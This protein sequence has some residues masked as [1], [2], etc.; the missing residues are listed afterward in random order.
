MKRMSK[1]W[2]LMGSAVLLLLVFAGITRTAM[3]AVAT[4]GSE[5]ALTN[6]DF[7]FVGPGSTFVHDGEMLEIKTEETQIQVTT[8]DGLS[9]DDE[10]VWYT[11][12]KNIVDIEKGSITTEG[13]T[14]VK[15][16]CK[17]K[18]NGPGY[19]TI[20]AQITSGNRYYSVHMLVKV[21]LKIKDKPENE[22]DTVYTKLQQILTTGEKAIV[23]QHI[24]DG[25]T[26]TVPEEEKSQTIILKY[27]TDNQI[28]N[29]SFVTW[30]SKDE[31]VA[32][33]D[34]NGKVTAVG[35]GT[36]TIH[37]ATNTTSA[38]EKSIE[39]DITVI[40]E[41][42]ANTNIAGSQGTDQWVHKGVINNAPSDFFLTTNAS[43]ATKLKWV[44]MDSSRNIIDD[45]SNLLSYYPSPNGSTLEITSA[46]AGTYYI[47][48]FADET[49]NIETNTKYLDL[50]VN[51]PLAIP[52]SDVVMNVGNTYDLLNNLNAP[53][54]SSFTK[55]EVTSGPNFVSV[56][57]STGVITAKAK[58]ISTVT[59]SYKE[60]D[61]VQGKFV[62]KSTAITVR[63]IDAIALNTSNATIFTGSKLLLEAV[64]TDTTKPITWE[65]S[66]PAVATVD[67]GLVTGVS[68]GEVVI[69]AKQV[70][71]GVT[72]YATCT[73]LVQQS[74][75][76]IVIDPSSYTLDIGAF[77]NLSAKIT[78]SNLGNIALTWISSDETVAKITESGKKFATV[79]GVSGG[80][81]VI[82]AINQQNVVVGFCK[83]T[84]NQ[85]VTGIVLNETNVVANLNEKEIQLRATVSPSNATNTS[86]TWSSTDTSVVRVDSTG[87]VT[88][89]SAGKASIIATSVDKPS[90]TAVC[91]IQ[92][93]TPVTGI[94]LDAKTKALIVGETAR[95]TYVV[96]PTSAHN[97]TV[98][99][100]SSDPAVATVDTAGKVTALGVG[101]TVI[102]VMTEDGSFSKT[103]TVTVSRFAN[104][105]KLD[106]TKLTLNVD[107]TYTFKVTL[108][109]ADSTETVTWETSNS[110]VATVNSSGKVTA[111]EEGTAIIIAKSSKGLTAYCNLTVRQQAT[112]LK[113]NYTKKT[114]TKGD[115]FKLKAV[116]TPVNASNQKVLFESSDTKVATITKE[117]V[118][119]GIKGGMVVIT[120][121]SVD[122]EYK[123]NCIVTVK[124]LVTSVSLKSSYK[125]G[126]GKTYTLVAKVKS[127]SA[128]TPKLKWTT[129]NSKIA[130]VD[131][132]GKIKGIRNGK[133]IITATATDGSKA[134]DECEVRVV[135]Q[136]TSLAL[137]KNVLT[138]VEGSK[139]KLTAYV[140]PK[141]ATYKT[142]TWSSSDKSIAIVNSKGYV[143]GI[144]EGT[145]TITASAKDS[146]KKKATC[147]V[148]VI[149][150][151]PATSITVA[152]QD[153]VMV[154]GEQKTVQTVMNPANT[155]DGY[156]W[157][158]DNNA[159]ATVSKSTGKIVAKSIGTAV[160]TVMTDSGK[161][162]RITVS[163]VGLSKSSLTLEQYSKHRLW[164]DGGAKNI[165]WD[166][167]NPTIA[168]VTNGVIT[169]SAVGRTRIIAIVNG[170]RLYCNLTVTRI[171]S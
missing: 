77:V 146:S 117:G 166:V 12:N 122:G 69:T 53:G 132:K 85:P 29:N 86:V 91:N 108:T 16:A 21:D 124:E 66:D 97:K 44:V 92:V 158:S 90:I 138:V 46:K 155:T 78:P 47:Q 169:T 40:V 151:V 135:T 96:I 7:Y 139:K 149:P 163:V 54:I 17:L 109:P 131:K 4:S 110:N 127:N 58:G 26:Q 50:T 125:L 150:Q 93:T 81:A 60:Y 5:K 112:G 143:S 140:R 103:C 68:V 3:A 34:R 159:V 148:K 24:P 84:V 120:A 136:V 18:R 133:V 130:T 72:K 23:L 126:K 32:K 118:V 76:S 98:K 43:K 42:Q 144:K 56:N 95:L 165:T 156:S 128:T 49:Y 99:W 114:V 55:I 111:K 35:A 31:T 129:S 61:P 13:G 106:K 167:E 160:I 87:K 89:V 100:T 14:V 134:K 107:A 104:S 94:E 22:S 116:V 145:V 11:S 59:L 119:K 168:T 37:I 62:E 1:K 101:T 57:P 141:N 71:N 170:R 8:K 153:L 67:N 113:L 121:T 152:D 38:E 45:S 161:K 41:P 25:Y 19:A 83:I 142:A 102:T 27:A 39:F 9:T 51:V 63:V 2:F 164:V 171:K 64:V 162:A 80:T 115:S 157:S 6:E 20:T 10:I 28:I 15:N 82:T 88:F 33:V 30:E 123:A 137:S 147:V 73:V 70:I 154:T 36:T 52:A 75:T 79:Q 65:S 48:A 105:L 74:V